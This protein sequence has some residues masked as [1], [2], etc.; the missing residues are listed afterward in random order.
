MLHRGLLLYGLHGTLQV[1]A[2][3]YAMTGACDILGGAR[4]AAV[5]QN[6]LGAEEL[7]EVSGFAF[8]LLG[9][10]PDNS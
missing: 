7:R 2:G 5:S 3:G 9:K 10:E 6:R 4:R 8:E 1:G